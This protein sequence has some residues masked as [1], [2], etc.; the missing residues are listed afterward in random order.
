VKTSPAAAGGFPDFESLAA[1]ARH[2]L[3]PGV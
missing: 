2:L 3:P 1:G